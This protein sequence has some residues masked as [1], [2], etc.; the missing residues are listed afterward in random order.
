MFTILFLCFILSFNFDPETLSSI[1]DSALPHLQT[2]RSSP[3]IL[4]CASVFVTWSHTVFRVWYILL[5]AQWGKMFEKYHKHEFSYPWLEAGLLVAWL[6]VLLT[7]VRATTRTGY[8]VTSSNFTK[9]R[10]H[11]GTRYV[12]VSSLFSGPWSAL[13]PQ[14]FLNSE[15]SIEFGFNGVCKGFQEVLYAKSLKMGVL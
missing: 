5:Q 10:P 11:S 12:H 9:W 4:R 14:Y 13:F 1:Q 7:T 8:I 15:E 2:P 6:M 3:K